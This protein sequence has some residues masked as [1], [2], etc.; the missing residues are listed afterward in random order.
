[1]P[2]SE[3]ANS[4]LPG[5]YV[6]T[7]DTVPPLGP[8][9]DSGPVLSMSCHRKQLAGLGFCS[10]DPCVGFTSIQPSL[11]EALSLQTRAVGSEGQEKGE[12][13]TRQGTC[14]RVA[15]RAGAGAPCDFLTTA[16]HPKVEA[17]EVVCRTR[18]VSV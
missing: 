10:P 17:L 15:V 2:R 1:M 6:Q 13:R 7:L 5:P 3:L 4:T 9:E 11:G 12:T 8:T 18:P 16:P 14:N